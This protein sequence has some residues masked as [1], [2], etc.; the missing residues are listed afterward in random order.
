MNYISPFFKVDYVVE[1]DEDRLYGKEFDAL[2][3][4]QCCDID[5]VYEKIEEVMDS[6]PNASYCDYELLVAAQNIWHFNN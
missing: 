1:G 3:Y 2:D 5:E 6:I 4:N